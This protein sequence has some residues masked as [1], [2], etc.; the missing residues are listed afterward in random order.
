M[1]VSD[2]RTGGSRS[3][4]FSE[5]NLPLYKE[6]VEGAWVP[7]GRDRAGEPG[8]RMFSRFAHRRM[9]A[10]EA[11]HMDPD[12]A[13]LRARQG[14]IAAMQDEVDVS[15]LVED[16]ASSLSIVSEFAAFENFVLL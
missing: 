16:K 10:P 2:G 1:K 9:T 5:T 12:R 7:C 6:Y 13:L 14:S 8:V 11:K 15:S 4:P 3:R